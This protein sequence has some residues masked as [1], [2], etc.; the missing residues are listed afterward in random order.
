MPKTIEKGWQVDHL[1]ESTSASSLDAIQLKQSQLTEN[2]EQRSLL[3]DRIYSETDSIE[4]DESAMSFGRSLPLHL[5]S[6]VGLIGQGTAK[7]KGL[8]HANYV[9]VS[10]HS[11]AIACAYPGPNKP[12]LQNFWQM[13][14]E[15]RSKKIVDLTMG[16]DISGE[17][18]YFPKT[19]T[20]DLS[21]E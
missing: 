18:R 7:T 12:E 9:S 20:R 8:V 11:K 15:H 3:D 21:A 1:P 5:E 17:E 6:A 14:F 19:I 16:K 10:K 4:M 13:V 2:Q